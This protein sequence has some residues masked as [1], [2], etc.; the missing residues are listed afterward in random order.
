MSNSISADS[1]MTDRDKVDQN[2]N[3][4]FEASPA[5]FLVLA[6]DAPRFTIREV[7][8]AYLA[9]TSRTREELIGR[10]VFEAFP[11]N[12]DEP[13][14]GGVAKLRASL[15]RVLATRQPDRLPGL[16]YDV[17]PPEDDFQER[18]WSPVNSPVLD[19]N[20]EVEAIIH[21][22]NDVTEERRITLALHESEA[23]LKLALEAGRLAEVTFDL[24]DG[25][26]H[27]SAFAKL[28]GHP[29]DKRLTLSEFQAQYHPNDHDRVLA[30]R[31]AILTNTQSFYEIEKRIIR[32]DGQVRWLYGRGGVQRH[33]DGRATSVTA[34]YLDETD[35]KL[36]E[37]ALQESE[38]RLRAVVEA[39]PVGLV[40][41]DASGRIISG[42]TRVEEIIGKAITRSDCIEDYGVDYV[43]FHADGRQVDSGE[44]PLAQVLHNETDRAELEVQVE[45]PDGSLRWVRYIATTVRDAGGNLL[46]AVVASLDIERDKRFAESLAKE[47][48]RAVAEL[49]AAQEALRQS[50]KMEAM[51]ALTGGVAHDFNNLLSPIIGGLDLLQRRG[52]GD[53]RAQRLIA[54]ALQSAERA[55]TLVQRLLA[56]AR[57]QPLQPTSVDVR[58]LVEGMAALVASTTG[59]LVTVVVELAADLPHAKADTNQVEMALLNLSVNARDAMPDGGK[60]TI[61]AAEELVELQHSA[62]LAPGRYV[63]MSVEDTG[64]GMDAETVKL[65]VEPFYSTKGV[66]K[67]TGLGLSMVH[68]LAG[69]S[70]GGLNIASRPGLGTKVELWLP[71]AEFAA[72]APQ[73]HAVADAPTTSGSALLIDDEELVRSSTAEMLCDMGFQV[74]EAACA[75]DALRLLDAGLLPTVIVTDH[76]MPNMT[77]TELAREVRSR[78]PGVP[79]LLISGYAETEGITLDVARLTKPFRRDDLAA[80]LA[81]L[82]PGADATEDL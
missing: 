48:R 30:E 39:A 21:N 2:F 40:F 36:A 67:G 69:Q 3:R 61:A 35:R 45:L 19:D 57:R 74:V 68:G 33:E 18:W 44:Y 17:A 79:V 7:N 80:S 25:I 66:G 49:E 4:L 52:V 56:F 55:K 53:E 13:S 12:P 6:P 75:D 11:D 22:A 27:S 38:A 15:E 8:N 54:G 5:P 10:G 65:S 59:P 24:P 26:E 63:R 58:A 81:K 77:G 78:L 42:N 34:V 14:V 46:G 23:R 47:V 76:L 1:G 20:G 51:G 72:E 31:A 82:M 62:N 73:K 71:V 64:S 37:I 9:A 60:L 16:R 28:L 43:A 70:G 50:Q 29:P 41:A 32:A